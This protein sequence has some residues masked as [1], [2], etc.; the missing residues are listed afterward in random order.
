MAKKKKITLKGRATSKASVSGKTQRIH[1]RRASTR[2]RTVARPPS[3]KKAKNARTRSIRRTRVTTPKV[4]SRR[5]KRVVRKPPRP[6]S[7]PPISI[8]RNQ[9]TALKG[10]LYLIRKHVKGYSAKDGYAV[11]DVVRQPLSR[12]RTLLN[13]ATQI[14]ELLASPHDLVKVKN[15][16]DR[17]AIRPFA[18]K[19][20]R[21]AKHYIVH[22]P[23][24]KSTVSLRRGR[25]RITR[26]L[27]RVEIDSVYFMFPHAPTSEDDAVEMIEDM[28]PDM[29]KGYYI[30]QTG[31]H[32]DTG[33][34]VPRDR[35]LKQLREYMNAYQFANVKVTLIE[36]DEEGNERE[37][38]VGTKV[39]SQGFTES[40]R[41]YRFVSTT[42]DGA[43]VEQRQKDV[44]REAAKE[45]NERLRKQ[46]LTQAEKDEAKAEW[47]RKRARQKRKRAAQKGA[48]TK[49]AKAKS[50]LRTVARK[51]KA[52]RK[53]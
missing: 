12:Q 13:K 16:R 39:M 21:G 20:L 44:R 22:K 6:I 28:L 35:I 37:R 27:G 36:E 17:K 25:V 31:A 49:R 50:A 42:L 53:K 48:A 34:P 14:R 33:E 43:V 4:A 1:L 30:M 11:N 29:P 45:F 10:A 23:D 3:K 52:T 19:Q 41:G 38:V 9:R 15:D 32:G 51:K 8:D 47:V 5:A 24:D 7:R 46:H 40:I 18:R 26:K 2:T